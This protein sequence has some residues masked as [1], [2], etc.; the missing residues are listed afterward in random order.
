MR[1]LRSPENSGHV[2]F[3]RGFLK[4]P[5]PWRIRAVPVHPK[6]CRFKEKI[7]KQGRGIVA[8]AAS[9]GKIIKIGLAK[10]GWGGVIMDDE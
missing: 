10:F 2:G 9:G 6:K 3:Q 1:N 5:L 4:V 8:K 7:E